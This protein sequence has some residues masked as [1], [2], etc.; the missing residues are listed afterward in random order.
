MERYGGCST[1][2]MAPPQWGSVWGRFT[3]PQK[4]IQ[5]QVNHLMIFDRLCQQG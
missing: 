1:D 5:K 4:V 2:N 3:H